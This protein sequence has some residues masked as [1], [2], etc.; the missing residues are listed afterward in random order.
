MEFLI[1]EANVT[2]EGISKKPKN[3]REHFNNDAMWCFEDNFTLRDAQS[4]IEGTF[5]NGRFS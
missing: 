5:R 2:L 4:R 3:K 1:K